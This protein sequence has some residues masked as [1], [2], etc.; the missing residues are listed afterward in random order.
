MTEA[1]RMVDPLGRHR[2]ALQAN[3]FIFGIGK[4]CRLELH[5]AIVLDERI[6]TA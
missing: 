6:H 1:I 3:A 2:N 5:D 4:R